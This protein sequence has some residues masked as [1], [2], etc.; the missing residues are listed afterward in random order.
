MIEKLVPVVAY[1][2]DVAKDRK[3]AEK[4]IVRITQEARKRGLQVNQEKI[5]IHEQLQD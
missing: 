4:A 2:D 1:M 5:Q 3:S